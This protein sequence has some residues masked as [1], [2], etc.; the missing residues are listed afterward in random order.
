MHKPTRCKGKL[1]HRCLPDH[2][3]ICTHCVTLSALYNVAILYTTH[4]P[5]ASV[6]AAI[7]SYCPKPIPRCTL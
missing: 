3:H 6:L 1:P 5:P 2:H 7:I 4:L